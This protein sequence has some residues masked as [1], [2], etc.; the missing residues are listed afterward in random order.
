[1]RRYTMIMQMIEHHWRRLWTIIFHV[2]CEVSL[3]HIFPISQP[4]ARISNALLILI[5]FDG[6]KQTMFTCN[7][8]IWQRCIHSM[9]NPQ[10]YMCVF[11]VLF[12]SLTIPISHL[13]FSV[14]SGSLLRH[15]SLSFP[16]TICKASHLYGKNCTLT[17]VYMAQSV[18][19]FPKR[20]LYDGKNI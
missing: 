10:H 11:L 18:W 17:M 7:Y 3:V 15:W 14:T 20:Q 2:M 4:I 1:M 13:G 8:H 5:A 19:V 9:W 16:R 12:A 6:G